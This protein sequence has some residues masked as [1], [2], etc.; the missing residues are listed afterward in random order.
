MADTSTVSGVDQF[1]GP[2]KTGQTSPTGK[3]Y[4]F[5]NEPVF[6]PTPSP[7]VTTISEPLFPP[8]PTSD[9]ATVPNLTSAMTT[10][11]EV[12]GSLAIFTEAPSS[13]AG[14]GQINLLS[15]EQTTQP[16]A[17]PSHPPVARS[18]YYMSSELDR[19]LDMSDPWEF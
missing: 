5:R 4:R 13:G 15:Q 16:V 14:S 3:A 9:T 10:N 18:S 1:P 19:P 11:N 12:S 2:S 7:T 8:S 17:G 6:S